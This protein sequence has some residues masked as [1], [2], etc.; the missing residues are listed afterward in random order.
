L[1][2]Y[3]NKARNGNYYYDGWY[4]Y[5]D[6]VDVERVVNAVKKIHVILKSYGAGEVE[7]DA[8]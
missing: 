3:L 6:R 2:E 5:M 7:H 4:S 8:S 1:R